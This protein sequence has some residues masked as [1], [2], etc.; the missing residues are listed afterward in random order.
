[1]SSPMISVIVGLSLIVAEQYNHLI[2]LDASIP[3]RYPKYCL[4][5]PLT[6]KRASSV[7]KDLLLLF[8]RLFFA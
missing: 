7:I 4:Y 5:T 2:A 1:M 8:P 6:W 3:F